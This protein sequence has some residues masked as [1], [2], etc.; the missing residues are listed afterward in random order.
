MKNPFRTQYRIVKKDSDNLF[1]PQKK[2]IGTF[3]MWGQ[4]GYDDGYK[5]IER[6]KE[7]INESKPKRE[8]VVYEE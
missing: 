6:A 3:L 2:N 8:Y 5:S 7:V 1:Y 4:I